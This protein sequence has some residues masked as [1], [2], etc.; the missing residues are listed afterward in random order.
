MT[1][2]LVIGI[3]N[4]DRGDDGAGRAVARRLS[5]RSRIGADIRETGGEATELLSFF[6]ERDA[7]WLI[8]ACQSGATPGTLSR[9]DLSEEHLP[10]T[11]SDLSTHGFGLLQA[12]RLARIFDTLP[13]RYIL[14]AIEGADFE[15]GAGLSSM[16][17]KA[18]DNVVR[19]I[20]AEIENTGS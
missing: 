17:M 15:T 1:R 18:L 4:P 2:K 13:K 14:Y 11:I 8:D 16:T 12:I 7:V 3:G 5:D 19:A 6:D 20:E 10:D 9:F